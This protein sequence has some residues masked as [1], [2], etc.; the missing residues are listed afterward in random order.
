MR[1][2]HVNNND[3]FGSRVTS[4]PA[5]ATAIVIVDDV[6]SIIGGVNSVIDGR[7]RAQNLTWHPRKAQTGATNG[8]SAQAQVGC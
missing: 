3:R 1:V 2:F 5:A 7:Q 8:A 6:I 4:A